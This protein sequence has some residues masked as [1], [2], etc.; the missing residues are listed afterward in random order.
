MFPGFLRE[1]G[2]GSGNL[3]IF[4]RAPGMCSHLLLPE[5]Y[6][7]HSFF[8]PLVSGGH[9]GVCLAQKV[10]DNSILFAYSE[11]LARQWIHAHAS[12]YG[13][14]FLIFTHFYVNTDPLML[15][16]SLTMASLPFV[17]AQF[18]CV[19]TGGTCSS[20]SCTVCLS[21]DGIVGFK[22]V[23]RDI[24]AVLPSFPLH[25]SGVLTASR[26]AYIDHGVLAVGNDTDASS[27]HWKVIVGCGRFLAALPRKGRDH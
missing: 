24:D 7:R 13:L 11:F 9:L 25:S 10:H 23:A 3:H 17:T 12:V 26:S 5:E 14:F 20:S 18:L 15:E 8:V 16:R 6:F 1:G 27:V 21:H 22:A 2:L 4:L 19:L